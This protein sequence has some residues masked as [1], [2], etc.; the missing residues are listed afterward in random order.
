MVKTEFKRTSSNILACTVLAISGAAFAGSA[1]AASDASGT[2]GTQA[3]TAAADSGERAN[4]KRDHRKGDSKRGH[5][6]QRM[7]KA[8]MLVPGYGPVSKDV[9]DS[10]SLNADQTALLEDA[11]SFTKENLNSQRDRVNKAKAEQSGSGTLDPHAAAKK[12]DEFF[13]AMRK[14]RTEATQKWL[15]VWDSLE[16]EQQKIVSEHFSDRAEK[17]AERRAER[18]EKREARKSDKS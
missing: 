17:R 7:D 15:A 13:D 18:E 10:L 6:H 16:A 11:K 4:Q 3:T 12:Q 14:I 8:A 2:A 5:K 9:V 1:L